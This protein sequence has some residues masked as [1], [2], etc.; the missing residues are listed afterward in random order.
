LET[1]NVTDDEKEF[2]RNILYREDLLNIF[3]IDANDDSDVFDDIISELYKK[4]NKCDQLK[5]CMR[6]S[7]SKLISEDEETGLCI[8]YS[9][10]Y[11]HL[12]HECISS[13]LE[14][15]VVSEKYIRLLKNQLQQ[16]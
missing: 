16:S 4:V 15:G 9:Y 1:D 12:T 8:L 11:M 13:Y 7:A 6:L 14:N 10:H 2:I 3:S 5:E